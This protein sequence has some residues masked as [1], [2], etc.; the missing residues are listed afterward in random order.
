MEYNEHI[1]MII[2]LL[3]KFSKNEFSKDNN[4]GD[5]NCILKEDNRNI[6]EANAADDSDGIRISDIR[7]SDVGLDLVMIMKNTIII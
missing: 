3:N 7:I 5:R 6:E 4:I 1:T 2:T